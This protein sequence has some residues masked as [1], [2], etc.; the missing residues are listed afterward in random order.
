M[1]V[2]NPKSCIVEGPDAKKKALTLKIKISH[3]KHHVCRHKKSRG[4]RGP[5]LPRLHIYRPR[6]G[7]Q[8]EPCGREAPAASGAS[9]VLQSVHSTSK[10]LHIT[11][12]KIPPEHRQLNVQFHSGGG[13]LFG[14]VQK[15]GCAGS[16]PPPS[17]TFPNRGVIAKMSY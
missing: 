4:G 12:A 15:R 13:D 8:S 6:Q 3:P 1:R 11:Q 16:Y 5:P 14:I 9:N 7:S 10:S 17:C 2:C